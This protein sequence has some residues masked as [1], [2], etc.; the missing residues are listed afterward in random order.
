MPR[1]ERTDFAGG[2]VT[3]RDDEVHVWCIRFRELIPRLAAE[4][5]QFVA[6]LHDLFNC[7]RID[8]SGRMTAST[9]C[10][11]ATSPQR[12]EQRF[13]HHAARRVAGAEEQHVVRPVAHERL[14]NEIVEA[15]GAQHAPVVSST[16]F[17]RDSPKLGIEPSVWYVSQ[18]I[19]CG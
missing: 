14:R 8:P 11:K 12:S 19:P 7:E 16:G 1:P 2:L 5:R 10:T 4:I 17:A 13:C 18:A 3:H 9:E 15:V 6:R